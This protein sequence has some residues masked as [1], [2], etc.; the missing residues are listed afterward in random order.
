M[1]S[2]HWQITKFYF[3]YSAKENAIVERSNK[4]INR[5]L[6]ASSFHTN[7]VDNYQ[8]GLPFVQRIINS[9][10][11]ERTEIARFQ[12][13]FGI[14]VHLERDILTPFEEILPTAVSLTKT[15]NDLLSLQQH[16][17]TIAEVI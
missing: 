6:L 5:H 16:Y 15:S 2:C 7:T 13:L 4:E 9:S 14:S 11:N 3:T 1:S 17:I 10:H 12:I 8:L